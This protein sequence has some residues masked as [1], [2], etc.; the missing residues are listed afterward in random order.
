M[1]LLVISWTEFFGDL[2]NRVEYT[3]RIILIY[4]NHKNFGDAFVLQVYIAHRALYKQLRTEH[5]TNI[6]EDIFS[7]LPF[8]IIE[9]Y[10]LALL[11]YFRNLI[12]SRSKLNDHFS[13]KNVTWKWSKYNEFF[14]L[15]HRTRRWTVRLIQINCFS[16][17]HL[18]TLNCYAL[19]YKRLSICIIEVTVAHVNIAYQTEQQFVTLLCGLFC[20]CIIS[21]FFLFSLFFRPTDPNNFKKSPCPKESNWS[22]LIIILFFIYLF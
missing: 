10:F 19:K 17:S 4:K 13:L 22:G 16:I 9:V 6:L 8:F 3:Q 12:I 21:V 1:V 14:D 11:Q 2:L 5:D 18:S 20:I 15:H 7:W